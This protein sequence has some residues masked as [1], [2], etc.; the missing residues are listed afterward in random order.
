[1]IG[2]LQNILTLKKP[3]RNF[4]PVTV[5]GGIFLKSKKFKFKEK[6]GAPIVYHIHSVF[7]QKMDF[8]QTHRV[9][10]EVHSTSSRT[11]YYKIAFIR[12]YS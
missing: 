5:I 6:D 8:Y 11:A 3:K 4:K 7:I 9:R 10:N 12:R 1:V 2:T